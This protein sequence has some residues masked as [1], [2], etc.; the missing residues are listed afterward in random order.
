MSR[1]GNRVKAQRHHL[2]TRAP[3]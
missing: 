1:C 3:G 2:R